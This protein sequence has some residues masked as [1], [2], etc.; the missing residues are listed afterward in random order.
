VRDPASGVFTPAFLTQHG[1]RLAGRAD[2]TG[3]PLSLVL[4]RLSDDAGEKNRA[5]RNS[6]R[7]AARVLGKITRAEDMASRIA[8][9]VFAVLCPAT[10]IDDAE[11]IALRI[12]GVLSNT[13]FQRENEH[14]AAALNV[15]TIAVARQHGEAIG[16]TVAAGLRLVNALNQDASARTV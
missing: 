7:Q 11:R 16:E 6:L 3:R 8:P 4:I 10:T 15:N 9:G 12:E 1:A 5:S 2:Q 13:A 14:G